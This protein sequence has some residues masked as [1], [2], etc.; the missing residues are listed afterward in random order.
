MEFD[1]LLIR[2]AKVFNEN[3]ISYMIYGGQAAIF[4]GELRTT[5][6]IDLTLGVRYF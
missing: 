6:D 5:K 3:N 1:K 4:H 2:I